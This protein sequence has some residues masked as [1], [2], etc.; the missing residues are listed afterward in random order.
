MSY[1]NI[2][3]NSKAS[4]LDIRWTLEIPTVCVSMQ[5]YVVEGHWQNKTFSALQRMLQFALQNHL[6]HRKDHGQYHRPQHSI[7]TQCTTKAW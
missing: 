2:P 7:A 3:N 5:S 4:Q 6:H 1:K